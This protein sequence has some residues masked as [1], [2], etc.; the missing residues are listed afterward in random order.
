M[1]DT[2]SIHSWNVIRWQL[3]FC[4]PS[5]CIQWAKNSGNL[6]IFGSISGQKFDNHFEL[7]TQYKPCDYKDQP[8]VILIKAAS[9][10]EGKT[11]PYFPG[12]AGTGGRGRSVVAPPPAKTPLPQLVNGSF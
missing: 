12:R 8:P 2:P 11:F 7:Q 4:F 6:V 9:S 3:Y 1:Y 10:F 5:N